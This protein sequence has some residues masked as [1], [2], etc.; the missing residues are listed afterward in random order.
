MLRATV[1]FHVTACREYTNEL[2]LH[3]NPFIRGGRNA[4]NGDYP[5][6]V[7]GRATEQVA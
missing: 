3:V 5:H 2:P 6:M 4:E 7:S 1:C